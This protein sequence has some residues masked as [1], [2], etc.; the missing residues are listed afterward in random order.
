MSTFR[1]LGVCA[2]AALGSFGGAFVASRGAAPVHAQT[3]DATDL[4]ARSFT[5]LDQRGRTVAALRATPAGAE[6]TISGAK[7]ARVDIDGAGSISIHNGAGRLVWSA[8]GPGIIPAT[9]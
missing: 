9:E 8:P 1:Y 5:V 2:L 3:P 7:G 4:R 6:L